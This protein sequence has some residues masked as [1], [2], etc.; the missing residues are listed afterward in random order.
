MVGAAGPLRP[1]DTRSGRPLGTLGLPPGWTARPLRDQLLCALSAALHGAM[2]DTAPLGAAFAVHVGHHPKAERFDLLGTTQPHRRRAAVA[3]GSWHRAGVELDKRRVKL[4][5]HGLLPA[6]AGELDGA[7]ALVDRRR[8][9]LGRAQLV[10]LER[11]AQ[12]RPGR[13]LRD[14]LEALHA[15]AHPAEGAV[16]NLSRQTPRA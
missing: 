13:A 3:T 8:V 2:A 15:T 10:T 12:R 11:L 7:L 6:A 5:R 9:G 14:R 1:L 16:V 4:R